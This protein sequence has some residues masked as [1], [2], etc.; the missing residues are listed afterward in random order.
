VLYRRADARVQRYFLRRKYPREADVG[1]MLDALGR[2]EVNAIGAKIPKRLKRVLLADL[3]RIGALEPSS[4]EAAVIS[5]RKDAPCV[6]QLRRKLVEAYDAR[7]HADQK[8]LERMLA[9]AELDG[10]RGAEILRYF[11]EAPARR[12]AQCDNC[13]EQRSWVRR[14]RPANARTQIA[15]SLDGSR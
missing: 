13:D 5:L 3:E 15:A 4:N 14:R 10:C 2:G 12:C 9:Y 7:R 6:E 1:A 11:G 8:R